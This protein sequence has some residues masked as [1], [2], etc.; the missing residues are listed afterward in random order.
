MDD[1]LVAIAKVQVRRGPEA[2]QFVLHC[3]PADAGRFGLDLPGEMLRSRPTGAWRALHLA[4][5]EWLLIG[6][7]G[8]L[9]PLQA[10]AP[11]AL[12]D[13]GSRT[14]ALSVTGSSAADLIASLCPLDLDRLPP[15]GCTRT[16]L[17]KI[18]IVLERSKG[19]MLI[20]YGR[21]FDGYVVTLLATAATDLPRTEQE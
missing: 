2:A 1:P 10:D 20:H 15:D 18:A 13:V 8:T 17:G 21:S 16:L 19:G 3:A 11:H 14:L 6:P 9:P 5:D 4:P 7:R 12:V